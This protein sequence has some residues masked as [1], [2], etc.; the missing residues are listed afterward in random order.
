MFVCATRIGGY[1]YYKFLIYRQRSERTFLTN[2]SATTSLNNA[3]KTIIEALRIIP[4]Y[5]TNDKI[6]NDKE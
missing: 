3:G 6:F 5:Y 4:V 1:N 2:V